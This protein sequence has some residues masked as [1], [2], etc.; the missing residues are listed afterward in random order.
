[1]I[2]VARRAGR[3]L[4][5]SR[6]HL[7]RS[8]ARGGLRGPR[9]HAGDLTAPVLSRRSAVLCSAVLCCAVPCGAAAA[10][11]R[12]KGQCNAAR[13]RREARGVWHDF[14]RD[15]KENDKRNDRIKKPLALLPPNAPKRGTVDHS[16]GCRQK[17]PPRPTETKKNTSGVVLEN[18]PGRRPTSFGGL[19]L[20]SERSIDR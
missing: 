14:H 15:R 3:S 11:T 5:F 12:D 8:R 4:L 10:N 2:A 19:H 17:A 9:R 16:I 20:L 1:M 13:V 6:Q 18:R 7:L